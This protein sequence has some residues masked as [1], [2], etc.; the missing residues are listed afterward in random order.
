MSSKSAQ[1]ATIPPEISPKTGGVPVFHKKSTGDGSL[2]QCIICPV[3]MIQTKNAII[4]VAIVV[5]VQF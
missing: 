3:P 1:I 4:E 2:I 5:K